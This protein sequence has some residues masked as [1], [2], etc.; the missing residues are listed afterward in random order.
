[1]ST[2]EER[3]PKSAA[4]W[5]LPDVLSSSFS[6]CRSTLS[7]HRARRRMSLALVGYSSGEEETRTDKRI[8]KRNDKM[9]KETQ[10]DVNYDDVQMELSDDSSSDSSSSESS[11]DEKSKSKK[12]ST[13]SKPQKAV[14][15]PKSSPERQLFTNETDYRAYKNQFSKNGS[16]NDKIKSDV[17]ASEYGTVGQKPASE[18]GTVSQKPKKDEKME[19]ASEYG[20]DAVMPVAKPKDDRLKRLR[21]ISNEDLTAVVKES[22]EERDMAS[23]EPKKKRHPND[24]DRRNSYDKVRSHD[25]ER[26]Y[27]KARSH[28]KEKSHEKSVE[29]HSHSSSDD[30]RHKRRSPSIVSAAASSHVRE[31]PKDDHR[32]RSS[33][34]RHEE[35]HHRRHRSRS[36]SR[37][38]HARRHRSR[39]SSRER[40]NRDHR[41]DHREPHRGGGDRD[42][43]RQELRNRKLVALGLTEAVTSSSSGYGNVP[44]ASAMSNAMAVA[45]TFVGADQ[46]E[47]QLAHVKA[48]TGID[49]P[50]YYNPTAINPLKYAEQIKKRQLLWGFKKAESEGAPAPQAPV[51]KMP[52][53]KKLAPAPT[54]Q[55]AA[56]P[57]PQCSFNKWEATNFGD[58]SANE[59]FRRLMGIKGD[60]PPPEVAAAI[61]SSG[62]AVDSR[63]MFVEQEMEYERARAIT[64]TQRGLGLGFSSTVTAQQLKADPNAVPPKPTTAG[65]SFVKK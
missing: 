6:W 2:K 1:M 37:E 8:E 54:S 16:S 45:N 31:R 39:T 55:R 26:S 49:L 58:N 33:K 11:S 22:E 27:D 14:A 53:V 47:A 50:K 13:T 65:I 23:V 3:E 61:P 36:R 21:Q 48:V 10:Q 35:R 43:N 30:R 44:T 9:S 59:K 57:T 42:N 51:V 15:P 20:T 29:R 24:K 17:G 60:A 52:E 18:Y 56:V 38:R 64:H 19:I 32:A 63:K 28:D 62:P 5:I 40:R 41:D 34:D 7:N 12:S 46:V 25:K 4:R